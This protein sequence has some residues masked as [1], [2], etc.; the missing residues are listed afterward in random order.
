MI[1]VK[2]RRTG[3]TYRMLLRAALHLSEGERVV[4]IA[5][6]KEYAK[7][8]KSQLLSI[9]PKDFASEVENRIKAVGI[10]KDVIQ[11]KDYNNKDIF[12]DHHTWSNK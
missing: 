9:L 5:H 4:L 2:Y 8:L 3:R 10:K 12:C 11:T 1:F 6:N 7:T